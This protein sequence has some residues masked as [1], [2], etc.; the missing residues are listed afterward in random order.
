MQE[1]HQIIVIDPNLARQAHV[2][3]ALNSLSGCQVRGLALDHLDFSE[4]FLTP[5]DSVLIIQTPDCD[6][7]ALCER[8]RQADYTGPILILTTEPDVF[9][10]EA[11]EILSLPVA[12]AHLASRIR[13]HTS[14]HQSHE[15]A[16]LH[17][18]DYVLKTGLRQLLLP[19]GR[20]SKL[21]E[22][23]VRILR[24][25]QRAQGQPVSRE[26]LLSEIWGYDSRLT[27]HTLETHIYR[28][29]QKSE[30]TSEGP[31]LLRTEAGGYRLAV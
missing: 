21:T 10:A 20:V 4:Q 27:T 16:E 6:L 3:S 23:E 7:S 5:L 28:L 30:N 11:D 19:D 13:A 1:L 14:L 18:G 29:R 26:E 9:V 25:L 8:I 17:L 15:T 22:K 24:Y 31:V 2:V 12:I